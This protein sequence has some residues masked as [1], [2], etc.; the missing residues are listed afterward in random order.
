MKKALLAIAAVVTSASVLAADGTLIFK[1]LGIQNAAGTG[2]YNV[3]LFQN[4][5]TTVGAGSLPGGVTLGLF[6]AGSTTPFATSV[7]GT[8]SAQAPFA[9]TPASQTVGVTGNNPGTTPTI[10]IRAWEG[11]SFA[12]AQS[13]PGQQWGEWTLTTKPLGGDPGGG[14]LPITPPT[15]T[16]WGP[17]NGSGFSLNITP[18][19][20]PTTIAFGILGI[21]ALALARRRK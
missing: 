13:T 3:P 2:T 8:S 15:L 17:E 10:T 19:P 1:T 9:V 20:E 6:T 21:G 18:T 12:A 5:S 7:L 14:A 11:A 4:G 16:G